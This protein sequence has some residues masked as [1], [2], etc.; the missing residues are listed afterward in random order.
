MHMNTAYLDLNSFFSFAHPARLDKELEDW[1]NAH[2]S[3]HILAAIVYEFFPGSDSVACKGLSKLA[4][5]CDQQNKKLTLVTDI[6]HADYQQYWPDI[7]TIYIDY[8]PYFVKTLA[9]PKVRGWNK[10]AAHVLFLTGKMQ[11]INRTGALAAAYAKGA[12]NDILFSFNYARNEFDNECQQLAAHWAVDSKELITYARTNKG[13]TDLD[14]INDIPYIRTGSK[15]FEF[16]CNL[17][18]PRDYER[19]RLSLV[20]E[21]SSRRYPSYTEKIWK[22]IACQHPFIMMAI[23][24]THE[25]LHARGIRDFNHLVSPVNESGDSITK[26][27]V[28]SAIDN[29][30]LLLNNKS[31]DDEV[32]AIVQYNYQVY[33]LLAEQSAA[34]VNNLADEF[35]IPDLSYRL[36]NRNSAETQ[37][38][39]HALSMRYLTEETRIKREEWVDFYNSVKGAD[40]PADCGSYHELP[41]QV[42]QELLGMGT[43]LAHFDVVL[44]DQSI[45]FL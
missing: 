19:T 18:N 45:L 3:Q 1:V 7:D 24:G 25:M 10:D 30:M 21:N 34:V 29:C 22:A 13:I 35:N 2:P 9:D 39:R 12:I 42:K 37:E 5:L 14:N 32:N 40:W 43:V 6:Q 16:Y 33:M 27:Q 26:T 11:F 28:D 44:P 8:W 20:S 4:Q 41:E 31:S 36:L 38:L 23:P 15:D 17:I